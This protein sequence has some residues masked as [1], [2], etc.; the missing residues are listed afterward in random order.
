MARLAVK[1]KE[2]ENA[3]ARHRSS[4]IGALAALFGGSAPCPQ[5]N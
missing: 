2:Q 3:A 5:T 4:T 1:R